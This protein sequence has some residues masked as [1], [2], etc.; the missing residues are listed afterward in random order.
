VPKIPVKPSWSKPSFNTSEDAPPE[1]FSM[2]MKGAKSGF[3]LY[4]SVPMNFSELND[5]S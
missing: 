5:P 4:F 2:Q 1:I 3:Y